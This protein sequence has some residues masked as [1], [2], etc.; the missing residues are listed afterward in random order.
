[1]GYFVCAIVGGFVGCIIGLIV[2]CC[3][4]IAGR[5]DAKYEKY[6]EKDTEDK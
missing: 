5:E 3:L 4:T 1:M 2:A 6:T